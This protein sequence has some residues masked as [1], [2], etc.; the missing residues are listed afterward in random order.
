MTETLLALVPTYGLY[1]VALATALSCMALPIPSSLIMLT[2]GA[3]VAAGDLN[4]AATFTTALAGAILGDQ[5]GFTLGQRGS[6]WLDRARQNA[7]KS[8]R[9]IARAEGLAA[10]WGGMGVF[11]SRWLFSPI[12]PYMN[13]VM[14]ATRMNR[15]RFTLWGALGEVVWVTIY[16]GLGYVFGDQIE[17]VASI[18]G[19]FSGVLAA[20][21]VTLGLGLWLRAVI[22]SETAKRHA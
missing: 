10:R 8:A 19:N 1:I 22:R 5:A 21:A 4:G 7:G 15:T 6:L 20:G 3:F 17:A 2:A 16:V 9:L 12:G 14:G 18:A 11:L 13:L